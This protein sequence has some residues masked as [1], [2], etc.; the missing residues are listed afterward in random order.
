MRRRLARSSPLRRRPAVS[1]ARPRPAG[2]AYFRRRFEFL[3]AG[4]ARDDW[5]RR[6]S[7]SA[8][9]GKRNRNRNRNREAPKDRRGERRA[10]RLLLAKCSGQTTEPLL[11]NKEAPGEADR[12]ER[13]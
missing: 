3:A 7:A 8:R 1:P 2:A 10:T 9:K 13:E 5:S 11:E 6:N 12:N 4:A